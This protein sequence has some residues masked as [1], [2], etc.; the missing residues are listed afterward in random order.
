VVAMRIN[1]KHSH[2]ASNNLFYIAFGGLPCADDK[3]FVYGEIIE[4][5][6]SLLLTSPN[7]NPVRTIRILCT[8]K[9]LKGEWAFYFRRRGGGGGKLTPQSLC[10]GIVSLDI[11]RENFTAFWITAS[12]LENRFHCLKPS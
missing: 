2:S 7:P 4:G 3:N 11:L 6:V 5:W 12:L 8:G 1:S 10:Q 9:S